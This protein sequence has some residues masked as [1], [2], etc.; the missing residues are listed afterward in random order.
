MNNYFKLIGKIKELP[1]KDT[2]GILNVF[3]KIMGSTRAD[4][5]FDIQDDWKRLTRVNKYSTKFLPDSSLLKESASFRDYLE[6][7]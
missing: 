3:F 1:R 5:P 6:G 2:D 7:L 4:I